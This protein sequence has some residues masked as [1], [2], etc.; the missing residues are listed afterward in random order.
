[1]DRIADVNKMKTPELKMHLIQAWTKADSRQSHKACENLAEEYRQQIQF[2]KNER[3]FE[4]KKHANE[5]ELLKQ[6]HAN[7]VKQLTSLAELNAKTLK[8]EKVFLTNLVSRHMNTTD[9][10]GASLISVLG[11]SQDH[12]SMAMQ[13]F[14]Q[15]EASPP[16][17][18]TQLSLLT[19]SRTRPL[20]RSPFDQ[21]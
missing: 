10:A 19:Q 15:P 8:E 7:I 14:V 20:S 11:K 6:E 21:G 1:M 4:R 13:K 12:V 17:P 9:H 5:V 3:E 18:P 2:L 16:P